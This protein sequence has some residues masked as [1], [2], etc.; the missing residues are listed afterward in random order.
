MMALRDRSRIARRS[1]PIQFSPSTKKK[2]TISGLPSYGELLEDL[3]LGKGGDKSLIAKFRKAR[4]THLDEFIESNEIE[5]KDLSNWREEACKASFKKMANY[6]LWDKGG[7]R[8]WP[9]EPSA[10]NKKGY[11]SHKNREVLVLSLY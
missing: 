8:F 4:A 10:A 6:F 3:G 5:E 9:E 2:K 7:F 11:T 1:F